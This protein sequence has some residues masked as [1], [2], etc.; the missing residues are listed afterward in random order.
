MFFL[1]NAWLIPA[2]PGACFFLILFFGKRMPGKGADIGIAG[3]GA[4]FL[5]ALAAAAKWIGMATPRHPVERHVTWF[6]FGG[7]DVHA[8]IHIDGLTVMMLFVVTFVS[9]MVH[10]YSVG[11]MHGDRRFTFFYAALSL[12]TASML[13]LVVAPNTLQL[14]VGW[15]LVGVCSFLLIGHWWEEEV[16]SS[17]AIKAFI[18]TRV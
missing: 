3:V 9:L 13:T 12:F 8:G 1:R 7:V 2:I 4:S 17:A 18:T 10:V 14:L 16:N 15:E 5:L 11:Y 6:K